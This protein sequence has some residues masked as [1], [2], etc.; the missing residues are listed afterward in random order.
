MGT[1]VS[2]NKKRFSVTLT[3]IYIERLELLVENGVY[4]DVQDAIRDGLRRLFFFHG[5]EPLY[6]EQIEESE[7]VQE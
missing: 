4:L 6:K 1:T 3:D 2:V 5:M 7:K